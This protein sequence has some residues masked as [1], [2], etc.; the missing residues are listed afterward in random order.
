MLRRT[1]SFEGKRYDVRAETEEELAVKI[2][3][4]KRDLEEGHI[5]VTKNMLVSDWFKTFMT[6]Y[7]QN[8]I[9][10]ET[11]DDYL[12]RWES[13]IE[14][15]IGRMRVKDVRQIHCQKIVSDMSGHSKD[16][17]EKVANTLFQVFQR[18]KKNHLMHDNPAEDLEL[19][20]AENGIRRAITEYEREIAL[21]VANTHRAG[22]WIKTILYCGRRPAETAAL[23][24]RHLDLK[25]YVLNVESAIKSKDKRVGKTKTASGKRAIPIPE[26]LAMEFKRQNISPYEFVFKNTK[27]GRLSGGNMQIMWRSFKRE[28]NIVAG[29]EV[30]R[31]QVLPPY[32][33]AD[34][35]V[36]Y[37]FRHTFCTDLEAA[38]VSINEA[39]R[40]MGHKDIS[41]TSKIY[42]HPSQDSFDKV[43]KQLSDYRRKKEISS[44]S[45]NL[46]LD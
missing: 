36:P 18:A 19:P 3:L 39:A 33:I 42:T 13:K 38:G 37:C 25:E 43:T 31:N 45:T 22:L 35:L 11:Y 12:Y 30:Y 8:T 27:G 44:M 46:D 32:K 21:K 20:A 26:D 2:A 40:L 5:L 16:Y 15:Y 14:P 6:S 41:I 23:Q 28:M 10:E 34:D 9:S 17:I 1:F 24:G 7:K 4:K 29:C